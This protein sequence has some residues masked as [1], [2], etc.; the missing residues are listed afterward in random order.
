MT[1]AALRGRTSDA[2]PAVTAGEQDRG[3]SAL[4]RVKAYVMLT[5][6]RII[7]LLLV[8]T[9]PAMI[10]AEGSMP[11]GWLILATLAGGSLAAGGANAVNCFVDRDI[12]LK[13]ERTS[14]RPIPSGAVSAGGALAF[15]LALGLAGFVF[16]TTTVNLLTAALA[17]GALG[18]YVLIYT[19]ILKRHTSANIVIGGAAGAVPVLCGW[20]AVTNSLSWSSAVLF[21]IIFK[22]TPP[23]FWALAI[24]YKEDY[25][26][27]G[28]PMLPVTRGVKGTAKAILAYTAQLVAVTILLVPV[29]KMG[30]IYLI[31]A[32]SLGG[33]FVAKA[34]QLLRDET[35]ESA[36]KLFT[37][38]ITYLFVLF[39][40]IAIDVLVRN[41]GA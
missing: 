38:S 14:T 34:I 5:K 23:H 40:A 16:L 17:T 8:T 3:A 26:A 33:L 1:T 6:P 20:S 12:D 13:M 32:L 2:E 25:R 30:V 27:A 11:S 10:L 35:V 28:V 4:Q 18:F 9:V 19:V 7:L 36:M 22:W 39:V 37:Y 21:L 29:A 41:P 24:K 15:G 31:A